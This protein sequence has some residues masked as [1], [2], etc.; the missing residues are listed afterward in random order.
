M[1]F[2]IRDAKVNVRVGKLRMFIAISNNSDLTEDLADALT[3][4]RGRGVNNIKAYVYGGTFF[5]HGVPVE[6]CACQIVHR[7]ILGG[8]SRSQGPLS[9]VLYMVTL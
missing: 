2:P 1:R 4:T 8:T 3:G 5:V 9:P 6:M 7:E